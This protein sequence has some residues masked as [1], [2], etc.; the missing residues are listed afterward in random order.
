[1]IL[2]PVETTE[3]TERPSF[4]ERHR[5]HPILFALGSL[6]IVFVL[7]QLVAGTITFLL[8][9]G[10]TVNRDNVDAIRLLTMA[11]QIVCILLPTLVLARLLSRRSADV[12]KWRI[13]PVPETIY[14]ILGLVMLQQV[15]QIYLFF[16]DMIPVP[17]VLRKV[18]DPFKQMLEEMFKS[19]VRAESLGE[20]GFVILVVAFV[21]AVVEELLF[22]G[23]IQRAVEKVLP[24]LQAAV[25]AGIV[26]GLYHFNPFAVIPLVGLGCYFGILRYRSQSVV[27]AMTA[28]FV[29]NALAAVAAYFQMESETIFG[30]RPE[31]SPNIAAVLVQLVLYLTVFIFIF[32]RYMKITG[33]R[34]SEFP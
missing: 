32:S 3:G 6:I 17:E 13:P 31:T 25:L 8:V 20:L 18:L 1:M 7:Y 28:H 5:V 2:S 15:F 12:F 19:L 26:F 22:R 4:V 30:V 9:G 29:N 11:G 33:Q 14:A 23:L 34:T 10:T 24:G 27:I 21:P 16:Q